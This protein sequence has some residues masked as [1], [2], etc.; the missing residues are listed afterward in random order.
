MLTHPRPE[1]RGVHKT[2]LFRHLLP[3]LQNHAFTSSFLNYTITTF[4]ME[5]YAFIHLAYSQQNLALVM[6]HKSCA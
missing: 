4:D 3:Y 1:T 2:N 5:D 6:I